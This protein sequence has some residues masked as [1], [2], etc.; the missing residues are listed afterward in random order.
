MLTKK[1]IS[2]VVVCY[3]DEGNI[4]ALYD[5]L[6][7]ALSGIT[8]HWEI[9]YVNDASPDNSEAI[10]QELAAKDP[11]LTL[12]NQ[13]RNFGA[14]AAFTAGM[15][16]ALGDVVVLLDGDLQDPPELIE[17]FVK[18][19]LEG[20]KVVYGIRR[21]REQSMG[22]FMQWLYH[23]FYVF[24]S[25]TAYISIPQDAG[26]FSLMDR[27]VVDQVNA[28]PE[29]D[30]LVRGLRA[31]VGYKSCGIPYVR[32]ER[33]DGRQSVSTRGL[34]SAFRWA[35]KAIFSFSYKPLEWVT[36]I[37]IVAAFLAT[38]GIIVYV[39]LF[40]FTDAPRGFSTV[41]VLILFFAAIQLVTLAIMGEYMGRIFEEV[42]GRPRYII[43]DI[44]NDHR[45]DPHH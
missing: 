44:V 10:L 31:W 29:R 40:F 30:R 32:P 4:R 23:L 8:S 41:F 24:F 28:L 45:L 26:E 9:I 35:R 13:S 21:K 39:S 7:K 1:L 16:Q 5:R 12:I 42:K 11:H 6:S 20:Y 14:Q 38:I 37:S 22:R 43:R 3:G 27:V 15:I 19:W 36:H 18:K 25:K 33:Y 34:V 2:A 17:E